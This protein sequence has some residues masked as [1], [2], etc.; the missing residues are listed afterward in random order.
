M[1]SAEVDHEGSLVLLTSLVNRL[2]ADR[3]P[4]S[5]ASS[6]TAAPLTPLRKR[7]D[8]VRPI[9]VGETLRR[10][11]SSLLMTRVASQSQQ[12]LEPNQ[13]GVRTKEGCEA[14][15]H[16]AHRHV[17]AHGQRTTHVL[18]QVD[19]ANAFNLVSRPVFLRAVRAHFPV[20]YPWVALC[21]ANEPAHLWIGDQAIRS[22]CGVQQRDPLGPLLFPLALQ[23]VT[24]RLAKIV[25][26]TEPSDGQGSDFMA[27]YRTTAW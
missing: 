17:H 7:D 5:L 3:V 18:L 23:P 13:L 19:L 11:V 15:V 24:E 25:P 2:A 6:L 8:G 9:A 10:P 12:F 4:P 1:L 16:A 21:Y 26:P 22:V 27:F 14:I 20:L